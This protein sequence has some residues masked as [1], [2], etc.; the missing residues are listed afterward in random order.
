MAAYVKSIDPNH[1]LSI[2]EEGFYQTGSPSLDDDPKEANTWVS[3]GP[4]P[5]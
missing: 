5:T 2:G 4:L 3:E 1:L